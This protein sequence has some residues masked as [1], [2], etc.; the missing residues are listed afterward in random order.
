MLLT[1]SDVIKVFSTNKK[2]LDRST[3]QIHLSRLESY[4]IRKNTDL[5]LYKYRTITF[6][7]KH[8]NINTS[9]ML[10]G[11]HKTSIICD[12]GVYPDGELLFSKH[13]EKW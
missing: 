8:S 10:K 5:N 7:R 4:C 1:F 11:Q 6:R 2:V 3:G 13:I 12:L 9:Y